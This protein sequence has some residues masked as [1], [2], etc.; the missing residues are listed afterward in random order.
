MTA[1]DSQD[2]VWTIFLL[3]EFGIILIRIFRDSL[4]LFLCSAVFIRRGTKRC[5]AR[6]FDLDTLNG[7]ISK[8]G[9]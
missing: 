3:A 9:G 1:Q 5:A 8:R 7:F 6:K 2:S 4:Q